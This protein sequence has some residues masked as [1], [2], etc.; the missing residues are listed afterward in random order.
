MSGD[1]VW[2]EAALPK[3]DV[4][5]PL[6]I[7]RDEDEGVIL[8]VQMSSQGLE[9]LGDLAASSGQTLDEVVGKAFLLYKAAS[10][11]HRE[12]KS[13]GIAPNSEVLETEFVGI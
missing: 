7:S 8:S 9:M 6:A 11:A 13:V 10:D 2:K 1:L 4:P 5:S 3:D 12:G